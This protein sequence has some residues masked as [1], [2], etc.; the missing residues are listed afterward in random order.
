MRS[1]KKREEELK[2]NAKHLNKVN[3]ERVKDIENLK[4]EIERLCQ[5]RIKQN[6]GGS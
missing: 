3:K 5:N 2:T 4:R 1:K 6:K